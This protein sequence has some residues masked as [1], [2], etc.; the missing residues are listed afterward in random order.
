MNFKFQRP[1]LNVFRFYKNIINLSN[2]DLNVTIKLLKSFDFDFITQH[3]TEDLLLF[4]WSQK[5]TTN[6]M[7]YQNLFRNTLNMLNVKI[8]TKIQFESFNNPLV[9]DCSTSTD[10]IVTAEL[11]STSLSNLPWVVKFRSLFMER[12]L[13]LG[14][15]TRN[16]VFF[17]RKTKIFNKGRYSRNRQIYRTGVYLCLW[18]NIL[19]IVAIYFLFYRFL[20]NFGYLWW[21]FFIYVMIFFSG[22]FINAQLYLFSKIQ[23]IFNDFYVWANTLVLNFWKLLTSFF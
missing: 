6:Y 21:I 8:F 16:L 12:F 18:V 9:K 19:A 17:L 23:Q 7:K 5:Q 20:F 11:L 10:D 15:I 4:Y 13:S 1:N 3:S 14:N 22:R 2:N